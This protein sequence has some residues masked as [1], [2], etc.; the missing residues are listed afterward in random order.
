MK[1]GN[2]C[3]NYALFRDFGEKNFPFLPC[4]ISVGPVTRNKDYFVL[5]SFRLK[6]IF[7]YSIKISFIGIRHQQMK[8]TNITNE[9]ITEY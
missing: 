4:D 9:S 7:L 3:E 8:N 6:Y 2:F 5:P 1:C